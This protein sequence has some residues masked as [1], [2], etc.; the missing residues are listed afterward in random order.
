[1]GSRR[2][3]FNPRG[4]GSDISCKMWLSDYCPV[5]RGCHLNS[6]TILLS[7]LGLP[8]ASQDKFDELTVL[9]CARRIELTASQ[10]QALSKV[11]AS[12]EAILRT[13]D[14]EVAQYIQN[15]NSLSIIIERV[16]AGLEL[17][18]T[19]EQLLKNA[20]AAKLRIYGS[21]R[22]KIN[23][24]YRRALSQFTDVQLFAIVQRKKYF[25]RT[26][27]LVQKIQ[28]AN[29]EE[30][31][32]VRESLTMWLTDEEYGKVYSDAA[33]KYERETGQRTDLKG[34]QFSPK[35]AGI[36]GQ[37][38][39]IREKGRSYLQQ[40]RDSGSPKAKLKEVFDLLIKPA[41]A[42]L[43]EWPHSGRY[44]QQLGQVD[45]VVA[46]KAFFIDDP[47]VN[48]YHASVLIEQFLFRLLETKGASQV[49]GTYRKGPDVSTAELNRGCH[50]QPKTS[51]LLHFN[52]PAVRA[53]R[54]QK[55]RLTSP[56]PA[57]L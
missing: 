37:L 18:S 3:S 15:D 42:E 34:S 44:R 1:M 56:P 52:E 9:N 33:A 10:A 57:V 27:S 23:A 25:E 51:Q 24:E 7:L 38:N 28:S 21:S 30:W 55:N 14:G 13:R 46:Q 41:A 2:P 11:A 20:E 12:I 45:D 5:K 19:E 17:T 22:N 36:E 48:P 29:D 40:I 16:R 49:L 47:S 39:A 54:D 53:E 31:D 4:S 43:R 8:L 50:G 6:L 26:Q 32:R 35:T